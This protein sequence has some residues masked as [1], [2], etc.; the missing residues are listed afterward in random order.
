MISTAQ[1]PKA[2]HLAVSL[3]FHCRCF[4]RL[5]KTV[6]K[7]SYLKLNFDGKLGGNWKVK[8]THFYE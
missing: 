2:F 5:Q 7:S 8:N 1:D 6:K 3:L 4:S